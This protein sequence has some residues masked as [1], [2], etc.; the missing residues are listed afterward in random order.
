MINVYYCNDIDLHIHAY[1]SEY[2]GNY[3]CPHAERPDN[4]VYLRSNP[5]NGKYRTG[6]TPETV[7]H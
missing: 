1:E 6:D 2:S 5:G 4:G 7:V 3:R